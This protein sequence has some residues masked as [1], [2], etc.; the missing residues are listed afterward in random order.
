M[1]DLIDKSLPVDR[2]GSIIFEHLLSL[3]DDHLSIHPSVNFKQALAVGGWYLWW[4]RRQLT[5][6]EPV[7]PSWRWPISI[8]SIAR[9]FQNASTKSYEMP[10]TRWCKP[11]PRFT[12]LNIDAS[13]FADDGSGATAAILRDD[14]GNFIAAQCKFISVAA[15]AI[16]TEAMAMRDGLSFANSLG[17]NRVEAESDSL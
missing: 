4:V 5:H 13:F 9:N 15:D 2:S 11:E 1:S 10:E 3:P 6:N 8:L 7:P 14:R 17:F 12:K 16:T